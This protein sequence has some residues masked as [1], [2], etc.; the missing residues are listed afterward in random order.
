LAR[1]TTLTFWKEE[2][3]DSLSSYRAVIVYI[4]GDI[5]PSSEQAFIEYAK[6]WGKLILLHHTIG[7][8]KRKNK[9][10][11]PFLNITLP[12]RGLGGWRLQ[13]SR[14]CLLRDCQSCTGNYVTS[15]KVHY[16][17]KVPYS[18]LLTGVRELASGIRF[19]DTEVYLNHELKGQRTILLGLSG[20][21]EH[22][23]NGSTCWKESA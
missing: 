23:A 6:E 3:P 22:S 13:L 12:A 1:T 16:D 4:H 9:V 2:L 11:F 14:A 17:E 20:F 7:S 8:S 21:R 19:A 5:E 10:W 18:N 15:Y